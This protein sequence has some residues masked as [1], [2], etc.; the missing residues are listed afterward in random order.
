MRHL[1]VSGSALV[2]LTVA[3]LVGAQPVPISSHQGT[4]RRAIT[5][6]LARS[7]AQRL[8][9]AD[10]IGHDG[11]QHLGLSPSMRPYDPAFASAANGDHRLEVVPIRIGATHT[12]R[13]GDEK[14]ATPILPA[15]APTVRPKRSGLVIVPI[16]ADAR[17]GF[18]HHDSAR[19]P[20]TA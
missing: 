12:S 16:S 15:V 14:P 2:A 3:V 18:L 17:S 9:A 4:R 10:A 19:G 13:T 6:R 7:G 1:R 11:Q 5:T 20:P 8:D